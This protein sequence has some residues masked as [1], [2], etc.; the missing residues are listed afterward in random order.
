MHCLSS[1][2]EIAENSVVVMSNSVSRF[3]LTI[4][5]LSVQLN[6]ANFEKSI[7]WYFTANHTDKDSQIFE[8]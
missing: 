3:D 5:V 7:K 6:N 2:R 1:D 8:I 4:L